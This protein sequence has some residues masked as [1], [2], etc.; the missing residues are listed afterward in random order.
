MARCRNN[1][2]GDHDWLCF[3]PATGQ[4]AK[5]HLAGFYNGWVSSGRIDAARKLGCDPAATEDQAERLIRTLED[6]A[7]HAYGMWRETT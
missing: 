1:P 7:N 3:C 6:D 2:R 5:A 4:S